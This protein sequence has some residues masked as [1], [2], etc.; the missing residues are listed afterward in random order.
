MLV[1]CPVSA[2]VHPIWVPSDPSLTQVHQVHQLSL[3]SR[4]LTLCVV[5]QIFPECVARVPFSLWGL[6]VEGVFT[7][8][9]FYVRNRP[10]SSATVRL[11]AVWP[12]LLW[13]LQESSLFGGLKRRVAS[14]RVA[15]MALC[16]IPTC[17]IICWKSFCV[18]KTHTLHSTLYTFDSTLYTPHFT[19]HTLHSTLY[20][21]H[22]ILHT[23]HCT[24]HFTLYTLHSTFYTPHSTL[25]STFYIPQSTL[26]TLRHPTLDTLHSTLYSFHFALYTPHFVVSTPHLTLYTPHS[27]ISTSH[28]THYIPHSTLHFFTTHNLHPTLF[29]ISQS[30]VHCYGN[31]DKNVQD[32]T[33]LFN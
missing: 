3:C 6:G 27:T 29:R 19:L 26:Y 24:P 8:R 11:R 15:D 12:C 18:A 14:F 9:C 32:I 20:T 7:Q 2:V 22:F 4:T 28:S 31:R 25:H 16:D 1:L 21:L 30:S 23:L 5:H 33:R 10:Q 13:V 17:F